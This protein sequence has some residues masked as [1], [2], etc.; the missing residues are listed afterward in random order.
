VAAFN[1]LS[2]SRWMRRGRRARPRVV[3]VGDFPGSR[4]PLERVSCESKLSQGCAGIAIRTRVELGVTAQGSL[5]ST[6]LRGFRARIP[7]GFASFNRWFRVPL[8]QVSGKQHL[9]YKMS[10]L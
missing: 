6:F 5:G 10:I 4:P 9:Y 3:R 2:A 1:A 8:I 7:R